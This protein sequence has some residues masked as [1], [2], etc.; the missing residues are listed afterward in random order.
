V[1][2]VEPIIESEL[3][4]LFPRPSVAPDWADVESRASRNAG[5]EAAIAAGG[6]RRCRRRHVRVAALALSIA[7]LV[8]IP[9]AILET[10][11][12]ATGDSPLAL[13]P[14]NVAALDSP[15]T[16][17]RNVPPF[18]RIG[19]APAPETVHTLGNGAAFGWVISDRICWSDRHGG[20][21]IVASPSDDQAID[22]TVSDP[23]GT[24][25]GQPARVSGIAVDSVTEV[26]AFLVNGSQFSATP[27][28]NWYEI[29]LPPS[30]APW[31]VAHIEAR[32]ASGRVIPY[33]LPTRPP[34]SG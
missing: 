13:L 1:T 32:T 8:A 34:S 7:A 24:R 16:V 23:D 19:E 27:V 17:V 4:R 29:D 21:C 5:G 11:A 12:N 6:R 10:R 18:A 15:S 9:I 14:G 28:A 22:P 25:S 30:A 26:T 3:D 20:G 31:G 2:D 33:D